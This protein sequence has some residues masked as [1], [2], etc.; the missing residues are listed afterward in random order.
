MGTRGTAGGAYMGPLPGE[1]FGSMHCQQAVSSCVARPRAR[2]WRTGG[3][4]DPPPSPREKLVLHKCL[5]HKQVPLLTQQHC[6][7]A[8]SP[9]R[10]RGEPQ[11]PGQQAPDPHDGPRKQPS[12]PPAFLEA[13]GRCPGLLLLC[14]PEREGEGGP[15]RKRGELR[16]PPTNMCFPVLIKHFVFTA[17][18]RFEGSPRPGRHISIHDICLSQ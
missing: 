4:S 13:P 17:R 3:R 10:F 5:L 18:E 1:H 8:G 7:G 14:C 16:A 12:V 9:G 2:P 6:P 15:R 11:V